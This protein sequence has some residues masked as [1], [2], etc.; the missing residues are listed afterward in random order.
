MVSREDSDSEPALRTRFIIAN[1]RGQQDWSVDT[2]TIQI[3]FS[4]HRAP[5]APA[6]VNTNGTGMPVVIIPRGESRTIDTY[7]V[8]PANLEDMEDIPQFD[9]LWHVQTDTETVSQRTPFDRREI[10]PPPN[11]TLMYGGAWGMGPYP[12]GPWY[13]SIHHISGARGGLKPAALQG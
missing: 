1:E 4:V 10:A 13:L 3:Q 6:F 8:L 5:I 12:W 2:R 11:T 7:H 9:V